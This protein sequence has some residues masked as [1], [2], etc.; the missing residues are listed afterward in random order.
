LKIKNNKVPPSLEREEFL[1]SSV[2]QRDDAHHGRYHRRQD[3][4]ATWVVLKVAWIGEGDLGERGQYR[5]VGI[6]NDIG[7]S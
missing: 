5:Y 2:K 3:L 4:H 6:S 7:V 1:P